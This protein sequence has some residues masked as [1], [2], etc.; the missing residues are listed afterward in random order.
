MPSAPLRVCPIATP[1]E[2]ERWNDL[3]AR[4]PVGHRHQCSWWMEPLERYGFRSCALGC[5]KGD[6]LVGGALFR[7]YT[8]PLTRTTVSEC[9]DGPI[10]LEW[11]SVW[12]GELVAGLGEMARQINSMAV[13][14]KDCPHGDVHRDIVAVLQRGGLTIALTPGS[15]D[16]V[17]PLEGRTIDQIRSGFNHGTRQRIKKGQSGA[18]SVRRLTRREELA[19]AYD[20]WIATASRKSF[21]DVRPWMGLEPVLRHCIDNRLGSVLG[22]FL[23]ERLLAAALVTHVGKTA[24]WVYGGYMDGSEKH[25]PTHVL[26]YEAIRESLERGIG[27]YNFGNLIS[28]NQPTARGV[29][30]FKLGFGAVPQRHLDTIIWKRKPVLYASIERLRRGWIGANLEGLFKRRLIRRGDTHGKA[31][32]MKPLPPARQRR[33]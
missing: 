10:F 12:A 2:R 1:A 23:D 6:Q 22:S 26:Q 14:I 3:A 7:S 20:A 27:T 24:T 4:S 8:V 19:K 18:L 31:G 21:T 28:E 16:A 29:D 25:C 13:V 30:E 5:W 33:A 32:R 11:E 17:L 15:A 9:L